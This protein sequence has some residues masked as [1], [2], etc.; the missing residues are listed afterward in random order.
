[1]SN[2]YQLRFDIWQEAKSNLLDQFYADNEV[3][4]NWQSAD[5]HM[6]GDCPVKKRPQFP[7]NEQ[8]REEAEKIYDF[9]QQ[10]T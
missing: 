8:I 7:T 1:M 4:Q 9:V 10:K 5:N 2:P 3:W 6:V